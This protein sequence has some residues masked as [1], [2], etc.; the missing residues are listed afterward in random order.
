[1]GSLWT[2]GEWLGVLGT[3]GAKPAV[4]KLRIPGHNGRTFWRLRKV[5]TLL[6][7]LG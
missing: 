4:R 2:S 3:V 1:M 7:E 5:E 6:I